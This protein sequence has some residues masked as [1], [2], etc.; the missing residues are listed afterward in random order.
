MMNY[1]D[2]MEYRRK[3]IKY[4]NFTTICF[5]VSCVC[6]ARLAYV[7][8]ASFAGP[9]G[10]SPLDYLLILPPILTGGFALAAVYYFI[11]YKCG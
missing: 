1:D 5:L 2:R 10:T 9:G 6:V 7:A 8:I 4:F 11:R 3:A